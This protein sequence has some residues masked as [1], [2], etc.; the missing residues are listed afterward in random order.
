MVEG[1]GITFRGVFSICELG[2]KKENVQVMIGC[3]VCFLH[4][5]YRVE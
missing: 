5:A 3:N 4:V 1:L 2:G